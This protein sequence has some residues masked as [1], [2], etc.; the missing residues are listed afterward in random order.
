[1]NLVYL[2]TAHVRA[3][4]PA[5]LLG[6]TAAA[7]TLSK[8]LLYWAQEYFCNFCAVGHNSLEDL[9]KYYVLTSRCVVS[10]L[11]KH[12]HTSPQSLGHCPW[13]YCSAAGKR[14]HRRSESCAS[15]VCQGRVRK[16]QLSLFHSANI[17]LDDVPPAAHTCRVYL[18]NNQIFF[19]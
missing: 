2:Y 8:T 16:K 12:A 17:Y 1:M 11:P 10:Y 5:P 13:P 15:S 18:R 19:S 9:I 6:F 4:P 7:I 14:S 3:W